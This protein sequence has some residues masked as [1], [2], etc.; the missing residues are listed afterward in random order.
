MAGIIAAVRA[1][2]RLGL[3]DSPVWSRARNL[4][5]SLLTNARQNRGPGGQLSSF[6][7]TR[8]GNTTD[9]SAQ[10]SSMGHMFEFVALAASPAELQEPWVEDSAAGLCE[11]L[12]ATSTQDLDCGALYHALSGLKVYL[13]RRYDDE[14]A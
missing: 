2:E 4:I 11:L 7:F 6:Y 8:P 9:L 12:E 1:K 3:A 5:D 14:A 10:L 13:Q